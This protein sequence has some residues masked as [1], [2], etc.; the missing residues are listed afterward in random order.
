MSDTM[1]GDLGGGTP[2][3]D[4]GSSGSGMGSSFDAATVAL[5]RGSGNAT[6][7]PAGPEARG[8]AP[9]GFGLSPDGGPVSEPGS[10][11]SFDLPGDVLDN[12]PP[13]FAFEAPNDADP[14]YGETVREFRAFAAQEGL[15]QQQ[16]SGLVALQAKMQAAEHAALAQASR[17]QMR[18]LGPNGSARVDALSRQLIKE[19]GEAGAKSLLGVLFS[20]QQVVALERLL[21][22]ARGPSVPAPAGGGLPG[23]GRSSVADIPVGSRPMSELYAAATEQLARGPGHR[24][25]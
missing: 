1:T 15:N 19:V 10:E 22:L 6:G 21:Q 12:L 8:G 24:R 11:F 14:V 9:D 7:L 4:N 13:G 23:G 17:E 20:A 16:V 18:A 25:R 5:A 2:G 3:P